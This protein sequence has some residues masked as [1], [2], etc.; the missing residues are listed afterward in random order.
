MARQP[1]VRRQCLRA[2]EA[3]LPGVEPFLQDFGP[4]P[5]SPARA[6]ARR[7]V[8]ARRPVLARAPEALS[9]AR[10]G[11]ARVGSGVRC[12]MSR[13]KASLRRATRGEAP[14]AQADCRAARA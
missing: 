8:P 13:A 2:D 3:R 14:D 11:V 4:Q 12:V 10:S 1:S 9:E 6:S 5:R 7:P